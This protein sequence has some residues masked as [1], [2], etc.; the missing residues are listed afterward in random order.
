MKPTTEQEEDVDGDV[1]DRKVNLHELTPPLE[2]SLR[3]PQM[4]DAAIIRRAAAE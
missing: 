2:G 3:S 1:G 4:D